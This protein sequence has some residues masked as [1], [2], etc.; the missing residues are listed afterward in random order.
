MYE[1]ELITLPLYVLVHMRVAQGLIESNQA[2]WQKVK[3][4]YMDEVKHIN[5][6]KVHGSS[7][8]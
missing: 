5:F 1:R 2:E 3:D 8:E 7:G 6:N 4:K